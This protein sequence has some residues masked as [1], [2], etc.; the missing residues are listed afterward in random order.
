MIIISI[1]ELSVLKYFFINNIDLLTCSPFHE[2]T[3]SDSELISPYYKYSNISTL[4]YFIN[5]LYMKHINSTYY[6]VTIQTPYIF[7][8]LCRILFFML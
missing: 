6:I 1:Y 8:K 5:M 2:P 4:V 3:V 7:H